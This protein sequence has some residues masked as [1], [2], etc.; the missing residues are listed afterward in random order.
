V[1]FKSVSPQNKTYFVTECNTL[2]IWGTTE[3]GEIPYDEVGIS[4]KVLKS[5]L[6]PD[7][8]P[9]GEGETGRAGVVGTRNGASGHLIIGGRPVG[10]PYEKK[11]S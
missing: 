1:N 3:V 5:N 4:H 10:R 8:S 2:G 9:S 11:K 6:T 7:P